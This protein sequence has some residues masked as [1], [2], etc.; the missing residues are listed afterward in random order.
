[1][2]M[3][4]YYAYEHHARGTFFIE[5][6]LFDRRHLRTNLLRKFLFRKRR[7]FEQSQFLSAKRDVK[8][9][10]EIKRMNC[11]VFRSVLHID[12]QSRKCTK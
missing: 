11:E 7:V 5:E 3:T 2:T 12:S 10:N 1:M 6:V 4:R 8:E 9:E